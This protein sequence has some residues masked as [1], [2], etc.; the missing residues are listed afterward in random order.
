MTSDPATVNVTVTAAPAPTVSSIPPQTV[1]AGTQVLYT[2]SSNVPALDNEKF[3]LSAAPS[4]VTIDPPTGVIALKPPT[5]VIGPFTFKVIVTDT[6]TGGDQPTAIG[7]RDGQQGAC[8]RDR[9][10]PEPDGQRGCS[11]LDHC[12]SH[13]RAGAGHVPVQPEQCAVVGHDRPPH[14]R[15]QPGP[16]RRR[17]RNVYHQRDR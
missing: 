10:D 17:E 3:S 11:R 9:S 8:A 14:R 2:A 1:T 16:P 13:R 12:H 7:Q 15:H 4:W 6:I 5:N